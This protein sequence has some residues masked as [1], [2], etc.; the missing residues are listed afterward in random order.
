M[1]KRL[2]GEVA[3]VTGAASGLGRAIVGLFIAEGAHVVLA[4]VD[5]QAGQEVADQLGS[6]FVP[7]DVTNATAVSRLVEFTA[8]EYGKL[9]IMCNNAGVFAGAGPLIGTSDRDFAFMVAV[10]FQGVFHGT[11]E[12]G[13]VMSQQRQGVI[14]NT[15]STGG[16]SPTEGMAVYSGTKAAVIA[17]SK[18]CAIELAPHGV[19]VNTVSPGT[20]ITGIVP[21]DSEIRRKLDTIQPVGY[22]AQPEQMAAG[23]LFLASPDGNYVTGHDLVVDGGQTAGRAAVL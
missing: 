10:N 2:E 15:A 8:R 21:D 7:T 23:V 4:D 5:T 13:R 20:M 18:A 1:A 19:R 17:M 16:S 12:A 22:A 9:D 14:V 11:R 6:A 3:I